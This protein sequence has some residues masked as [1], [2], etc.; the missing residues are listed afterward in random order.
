MCVRA[1]VHNCRT[2]HKTTLLIIFPLI[3]QTIIIVQMM[4]TGGEGVFREFLPSGGD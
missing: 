1:I 2:Q 4:S 3:L